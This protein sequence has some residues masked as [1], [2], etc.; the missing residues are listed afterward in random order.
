MGAGASPQGWR[1]V[2][3]PRIDAPGDDLPAAPVA[4]AEERRL[5]AAL[6]AG[7]EAAFALLL[8]RHHGMLLRLARLYVGDPAVAEEVVQ[9]TW[10]GV[11]RG[12]D[13]FEARASLKTWIC[14]ILANR[15]RTR[16]E[17]EGRSIPFSALREAAGEAGEAVE[18][19]RFHPP[20]HPSAGHWAAPPRDWEVLPEERLLS[21]ETRERVRAAIETLPPNQRA[22]ISLRD[23]DGWSAAEVC[24]ALAISETNQ[25]VLLHRA[26]ARVRQTLERYFAEV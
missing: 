9:E 2:D 5:V 18:P 20:G 17:R 15:A 24:N 8:D 16:A 10:L 26:R 25:R 23:V 21:G 11:L 19:D 1:C 12:L 14:R 4:T 13:R 3:A 6:R 22:V 7:D